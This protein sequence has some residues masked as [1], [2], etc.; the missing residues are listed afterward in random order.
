MQSINGIGR[1]LIEVFAGIGGDAPTTPLFSYLFP[2]TQHGGYSEDWNEQSIMHQLINFDKIKKSFG[3][4]GLWSLSWEAFPLGIKPILALQNI[5]NNQNG[6]TIVFTPKVNYPSVGAPRKFTVNII[7]PGLHIVI[8]DDLAIPGNFGVK[9]TLET[10]TV[11]D[12]NMF[13]PNPFVPPP[14][15]S[16]MTTLGGIME[17]NK[18]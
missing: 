9:I 7:S 2:L 18:T 16:Y 6:N 13:D 15:V 1:S 14:G 3:F 11:M 12:I 8:Y 5:L 17:I 4:Y 10:T